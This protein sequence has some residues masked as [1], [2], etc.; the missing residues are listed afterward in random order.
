MMDRIGHINIRTPLFDETLA[1]Y[2][3]LLD[4][5]RGG[6][7]TMADQ[8]GNAWLYDNKGR[9]IVHVNAPEPGEAVPEVGS[10]GRVHHVAF[11][12]QDLVE[13][14]RRIKEMGL[15]HK[16][17][18]I[19]LVPGLTLLVTQDPNGIILELAHGTD[20]CLNPDFAK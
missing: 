15:E 17:Y 16:R 11:D 14:E 5:R 19:G 13:M 3:K 7:L 1:F 4:L 2:E 20:L 8:A 18:D 12:I 9:A 6:A 10:R